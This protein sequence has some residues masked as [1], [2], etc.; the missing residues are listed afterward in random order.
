MSIAALFIIVERWKQPRCPLM[1]E[2]LNKLWS[3]HTMQYYSA[4]N[5]KEI[6]TK[7]K[8]SHRNREQTSGCQRGGGGGRR[9]IGEGD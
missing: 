1:N 2:W 6:L 7:Q 4:L 5:K 8:Q 9:D 3:L